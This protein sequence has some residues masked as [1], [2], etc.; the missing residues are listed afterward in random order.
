MKWDEVKQVCHHQKGEDVILLPM[1][2]YDDLTNFKDDE[3]WEPCQLLEES[4]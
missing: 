4:C 2:C 3:T 1:L